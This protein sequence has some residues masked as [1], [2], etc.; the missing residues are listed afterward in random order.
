MDDK[1]K[2]NEGKVSWSEALIATGTLVIT[3]LMSGEGWDVFDLG[4]SILSL[5]LVVQFVRK[6]KTIIKGKKVPL[7]LIFAIVVT[8]LF[9]ASMAVYGSFSYY[10]LSDVLNKRIYCDFLIN[11]EKEPKE[12]YKITGH[13]LKMAGQGIIDECG[14]IDVISTDLLKTLSTNLDSL[15]GKEYSYRHEL[16]SEIKKRLPALKKK[17]GEATGN[18]ISIIETIITNHAIKI[19]IV[20]RSIAFWQVI[21]FIAAIILTPFFLPSK[22]ESGIQSENTEQKK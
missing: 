17:N 15:F 13:T 12:V 5:I 1:S 7:V 18:D 10:N 9:S 19:N 21:I 16:Q 8:A 2:A 14:R 3:M 11:A 4:L 6:N 22:I 20:K